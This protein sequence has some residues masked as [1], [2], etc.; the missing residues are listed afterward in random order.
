MQPYVCAAPY[1]QSMSYGMFC[2]TSVPN[3]GPEKETQPDSGH[4]AT[5]IYNWKMRKCF[6]LKY[7]WHWQEKPQEARKLQLKKEKTTRVWK[8]AEA[9]GCC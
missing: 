4:R 6:F 9:G 5:E 3:T 2:L 7:L 1:K 8:E